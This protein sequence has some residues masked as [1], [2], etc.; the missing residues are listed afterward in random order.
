MKLCLV[1]FSVKNVSV[2]D[3]HLGFVTKM[4]RRRMT[5]RRKEGGRKLCGAGHFVVQDMRQMAAIG[6]IKAMDKKTSIEGNDTTL[7]VKDSKK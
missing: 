4:T 6:V 1:G 3:I 7:A 5:G 2:K